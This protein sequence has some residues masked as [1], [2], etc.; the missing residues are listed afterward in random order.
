LALGLSFGIEEE[1]PVVVGI[2]SERT[3][4]KVRL[5]DSRNVTLLNLNKV[6]IF[7]IATP[8]LARESMVN[9]V[10]TD[11]GVTSCHGII[12]LVH[13]SGDDWKGQGMRVSWSV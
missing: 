10:L 1:M 12:S 2:P 13:D 5:R 8:A 3:M 9:A 7:V 6:T 4:K 11:P